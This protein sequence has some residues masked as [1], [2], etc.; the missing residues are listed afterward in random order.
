MY[1]VR[2]VR[3]GGGLVCPLYR[4]R[5]LIFHQ[6]ARA[7][8]AFPLALPQKLVF[9]HTG[10]LRGRPP[11]PSIVTCFIV[12]LMCELSRYLAHDGVQAES[13]GLNLIVTPAVCD[14]SVTFTHP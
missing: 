14:V 3:A 8:T 1:R 7:G 10:E 13:T 12:V 2:V 6:L 4:R 9:L 5:T 11:R